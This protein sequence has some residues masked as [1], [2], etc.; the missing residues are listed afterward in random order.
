MGAGAV[1]VIAFTSNMP[2]HDRITSD[3]VTCSRMHMHYVYIER[4]I[5]LYMTGERGTAAFC[6]L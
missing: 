5:L 6:L 2:M 1:N 3:W 4:T